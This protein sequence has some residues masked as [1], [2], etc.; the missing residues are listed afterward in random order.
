[1]ERLAHNTDYMK[2]GANARIFRT[3]FHMNPPIMRSE[4][5]G[6]CGR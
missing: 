4:S 1:V 5:R 6:Y 2:L 3:Q